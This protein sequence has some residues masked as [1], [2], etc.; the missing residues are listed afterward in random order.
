MWSILL[1]F[2]HK[3]TKAEA[4]MPCIIYTTLEI[5]IFTELL[6]KDSQL[7]TLLLYDK[8]KEW[9]DLGEEGGVRRH[10]GDSA[11]AFDG[12][13]TPKGIKSKRWGSWVTM[14][15]P[16]VVVRSSISIP[17]VN[18]GLKERHTWVALASAQEIPVTDQRQSTVL[19]WTGRRTVPDWVVGK[20]FRYGISHFCRPVRGE[21][22]ER[23]GH[24]VSCLG[25]QVNDGTLVKPGIIVGRKRRWV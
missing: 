21:K 7:I 25:H 17:R 22:W 6:C 11:C 19:L 12:R 4:F 18:V 2:T 9:R 14:E 16:S 24:Q 13:V 1:N 5:P 23:K 10:L 3:M 8:Y 20:C 15:D